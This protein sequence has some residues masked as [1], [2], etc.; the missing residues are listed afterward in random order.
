MIFSA[1]CRPLK[2]SVS[3]HYLFVDGNT[4]LQIHENKERGVYIRH[5]TELFMQDAEGVMQVF[6]A[7]AERR[8]VAA[9]SL[10]T[11]HTS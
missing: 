5:V 2:V 8:A 11:N 3:S 10:C 1:V 7:G 4:N 6:D 9:T